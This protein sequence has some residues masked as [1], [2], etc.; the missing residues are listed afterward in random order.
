MNIENASQRQSNSLAVKLIAAG[1]G[2]LVFAWLGFVLFDIFDL[3][4]WGTSLHERMHDRHPAR[5]QFWLLFF[6]EGGPVEMV[7]WLFLSAAAGMAFHIHGRLAAEKVA[8]TA[9]YDNT[10]RIFWLLMGIAFM[11][12]VVEDA[13]NPRHW[14][15]HFFWEFAGDDLGMISERVYFIALGSIPL[16]ALVFFGRPVLKLPWPRNFLLAGYF[17]YAIAAGGSA[18]RYHWYESAGNLFYVRILKES[19]P[20]LALGNEGIGF[21]LMDYLAEE[22]LELIGAVLLTATAASFLRSAKR[23]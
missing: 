2:F 19:L 4:G 17:F 12:M 3:F 5:S 15:R 16:A 11:L 7:Q 21:W 22:S 8:G 20:P 10:A 1:F 9:G 18:I 6:G 13:G 14:L 23:F